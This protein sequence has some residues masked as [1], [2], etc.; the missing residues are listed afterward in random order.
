VKFYSIILVFALSVFILPGC[1]SSQSLVKKGD[2]MKEAGFHKDAADFYYQALVKK[3]SNVKAKIGMAESGQRTLNDMLDRFNRT[4]NMG[5]TYDA[6]YQFI[7]A[8]DYKDKINRV[9]VEL[10]L[11]DH[12]TESFETSKAIVLENLYEEANS[13]LDEKKFDLAEAK[14]KEVKA[15]EPNYRDAKDLSAVAY[16]EPL[17]IE[18][19]VA[20][21]NKAYRMAYDKFELVLKRSENYKDTKELQIEAVEKGRFTIA[22]VSFENVSGTPAMEKKISAYILDE[23]ASIK[24]PF[25]RIVDRDDIDKILEEQRFS[26][27]GMINEQS[28]T[29]VGE[30]IGA[31]A[32]LTGKLL[33]YKEVPGRTTY[34]TK[35]GYESYSVKKTNSETGAE[36]YELR[37]KPVTY[38][39]HSGSSSVRISFQYKMISL[40]TGEI[41]FS[42][43]VEREARDD[44][45][46]ITYEGNGA[47]LYPAN[48]NT[49]NTSPS[50]KSNLDRQLKGARNLKSTTE[51]SN[52]IFSTISNQ[53]GSE[54]LDHLKQ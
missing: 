30:L 22:L 40:E 9:G 7:E 31:K 20:L 25:L 50:A 47:Q 29:K 11:P 10:N 37:Y 35:N 38:R 21:E 27:S 44:V 2:K 42:K 4:N 45:S 1:G 18:G 36:Y 23:L 13:L 34:T 12:Y 33:D 49:R 3:R 43:I 32:L 14:F 39:E 51:L 26:L 16:S 15:L 24:D 17:Y 48:G 41:L 19:K 5:N 46:F 53:V 6:V 28:A 52:S 8:R 54:V